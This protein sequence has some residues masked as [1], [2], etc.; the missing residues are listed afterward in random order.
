MQLLPSLVHVPRGGA[1]SDRVRALLAMIEA[2]D[3]ELDPWSASV[4]PRLLELLLIELLRERRRPAELAPSLL[5]GMCDPVV[6]RALMALHGDIARSWTLEALAK[7]CGRSRSA[8]NQ[9]FG[10]ALG[11]A[12][13][14]YLQSIRMAV[15]KEELRRRHRGVAEIALLVGFQSS[16]AFS[17]AFARNAGC[18]PTAYAARSAA[19]EP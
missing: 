13:M 3:A 17:A 12:P 10:A 6:S 7:S 18:S 4:S 1:R 8:F 11:M 19:E 5:A 15:A 14:T 2:E 9:R 16:S